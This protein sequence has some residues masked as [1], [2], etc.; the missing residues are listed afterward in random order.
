MVGMSCAKKMLKEYDVNISLI[1]AVL[2]NYLVLVF[3]KPLYLQQLAC[4]YSD[5][6]ALTGH[7]NASDVNRLIS[8]LSSYAH[9][10]KRSFESSHSG[11]TSE[12]VGGLVVLAL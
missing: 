3:P 4:D 9:T 5:C 1:F 6:D 2:G 12:P 8:S 7:L 10:S 11:L